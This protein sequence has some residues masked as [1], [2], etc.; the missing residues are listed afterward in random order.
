M[1]SMDRRA[2]QIIYGI[3]FLLFWALIFTGVYFIFFHAAASCFDGVQNQN[4][5]GID[6]GSVCPTSCLPQTLAPIELVEPVKNFIVDQ[7]HLSFLA[8]VKNQN[9]AYAAS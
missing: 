5:E 3:A 2:K 1:N 8:T 4:E 9:P 7:N 6:C